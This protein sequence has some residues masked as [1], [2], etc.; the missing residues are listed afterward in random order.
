MRRTSSAKENT[1]VATSS[2]NGTR[3]EKASFELTSSKPLPMA[4]PIIVQI[5][6]LAKGASW[7][8]RMSPRNAMAEER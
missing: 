5:V 3:A 6:S 4:P 2:R 8:A 7:M 1:S